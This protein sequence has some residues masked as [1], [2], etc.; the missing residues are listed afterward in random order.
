MLTGLRNP[1]DPGYTKES[2]VLAFPQPT[3][4]QVLFLQVETVTV[5]HS[6]KSSGQKLTPNAN[7]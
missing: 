1:T 4:D 6:A 3:G 5:Q 2:G 7:P